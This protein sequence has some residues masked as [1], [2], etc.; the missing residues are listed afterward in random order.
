MNMLEE[1][2]EKG[3]TISK[4]IE[5]IEDPLHREE[6]KTRYENYEPPDNIIEEIRK[7]NEKRLIVCFSG[8]WCKDCKMYVPILIKLLKKADNFNLCAVIIDVKKNME[9]AKKFNVMRIPTIIVFD[10]KHVEL[11]RIIESPSKFNTL[12]EELIHV[13]K[14]EFP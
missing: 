7:I 5:S 6:F 2:F 4:Y 1:T 9:L 3:I 14:R 13:L 10:E 12:E 8:S 11:G